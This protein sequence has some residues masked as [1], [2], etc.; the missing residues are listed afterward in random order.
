MGYWYNHLGDSEKA[1]TFLESAYKEKPETKY[2]EIELAYAY[3]A[4]AQ[5][6][7][8]KAILDGA[9]KR[10]PENVSLGS[11]L[12]YANVRSG[13]HQKAIELYLHFIPLCPD[14]KKLMKSEMAMNLAKAY[15]GMGLKEEQAKW[16]KKGIEW[17]PE[18]SPVYN[19]Y[20]KD[21]KGA[22]QRS[23]Q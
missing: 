21:S 18:G 10:D 13:N 20:K 22:T 14:N 3:N 2:V 23:P 7:K 17:A 5:Y 6:D 4:L 15:G 8:A 11:E 16:R 1:L 12:A 19:D 9:L